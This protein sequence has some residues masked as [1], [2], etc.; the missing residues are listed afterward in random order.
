MTFAPDHAMS[1]GFDAFRHRILGCI[2]DLPRNWASL[3]FVIYICLLLYPGIMASSVTVMAVRS[4]ETTMTSVAE[5]NLAIAVPTIAV[6]LLLFSGARLVPTVLKEMRLILALTLLAVISI[7]SCFTVNDANVA[8][9]QSVQ[10][11]LTIV[12]FILCLAFWENEP[13]KIDNA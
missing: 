6:F 10:L 8:I 1:T 4:G 5:G 3:G 11:L 2:S 7:V 9:Q 12:F 13:R